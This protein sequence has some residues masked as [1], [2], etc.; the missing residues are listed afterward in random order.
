MTC[1]KCRLTGCPH[2]DVCSQ[3]RRMVELS[4][5]TELAL[6]GFSVGFAIIAVIV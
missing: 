4:I 3:P 1:D 5:L 6:I 2:P